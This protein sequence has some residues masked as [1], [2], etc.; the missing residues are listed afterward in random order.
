MVLRY[1]I[2]A[3]LSLVAAGLSCRDAALSYWRNQTALAYDQ[4]HAPESMPAYF[5]KDPE[6]AV[7][8]AEARF[9]AGE[10]KLNEL[11]S[12][13]ANAKAA[14]RMD[15]LNPAAL[16]D[17]G[18]VAEA[19]RS[20]S[21]L[22]FFQLAERLSRREVP[23]E[24]VLERIAAR[25]D[26]IAGAVA[27][28]DH[29]VSVVPSLAGTIF[30]PMVPAL[31]QDRIRSTFI[32]YAA[33]PWF[34]VLLGAA[35][36]R[37]GNP[38]AI[39]AM[40][41]AAAPYQTQA[42]RDDLTSRLFSHVIAGGNINAARR[43]LAGLPAPSRSAA[44]DIGFTAAT[45]DSRLAPF[46]WMLNNDDVIGA[47]LARAR[48]LAVSVAAE[49]TGTVATRTTLI[50]PGTYQLT[51]TV[52][53]AGLSPR[54]G[55]AWDVTCA[56][57]SAS[58]IWHRPLPIHEGKVTYRSTIVI[59]PACAAQLWRLQA[60]GETGSE[61]VLRDLVLVHPLRVRAVPSG[62]GYR[63]RTLS[64]VCRAELRARWIATNVERDCS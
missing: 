29:I 54:A 18:M 8:A 49:Q 33:R 47:R 38:D 2:I 43:L 28:I 20:G 56:G 19:H 55:L 5:A 50:P 31:A 60:T 14:L 4:G 3:P 26:D 48:A 41:R 7:T 11:P 36:E 9:P 63:E 16:Y 37:S 17:L 30:P 34:P 25:Q 61:V 51:Q 15:P 53:Y 42:A 39:A 12:I 32:A 35:I 58:P 23:N 59:P 27:R 1:F 21:G 62:F 57:M 64:A 52:V 10:V 13:A 24:I 40:I 22:N 44:A 45:S 46:S 6:I